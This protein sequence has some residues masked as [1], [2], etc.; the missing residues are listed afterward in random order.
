MKGLLGGQLA[1]V[2]RQEIDDILRLESQPDET[3]ELVNMVMPSSSWHAPQ[4]CVQHASKIFA[5]L[6]ACLR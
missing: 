5:S 4:S 6:V 1:T 3:F 2:N